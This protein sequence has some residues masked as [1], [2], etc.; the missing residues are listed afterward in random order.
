MFK[1]I[2]RDRL[3]ISL[4]LLSILIKIFS[5]DPARVERYYT[6]GFYPVISGVLRTLLGWIPFS[7]GDLL[8]IAAFIF[9]MAKLWKLVRLL[10]AQALKD[11]LSWD[12][13]KKYFRWV[14]WIYIV[15]N[16]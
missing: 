1:T 7:F 9:L 6:F 8:Y 15:F 12:L 10:A 14:L 2:I 5:L 4:L 16:V 11:Y 13:F 3:L